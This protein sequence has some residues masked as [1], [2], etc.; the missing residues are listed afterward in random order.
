ME[1][2]YIFLIV[3]DQHY[4]H[5][6][7]SLFKKGIPYLAESFPYKEFFFGYSF[8][9]IIIILFNPEPH[10]IPS[11]CLLLL[12]FSICSIIVFKQLLCNYFFDNNSELRIKS[13]KWHCLIPLPGCSCR[14]P[15]AH[16][17]H[18]PAGAI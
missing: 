3:G 16:T 8:L 5:F 2:K 10:P 11:N 17:C 9:Q 7:M 18:E 14:P 1:I 13:R 4:G 15:A 12:P 6:F